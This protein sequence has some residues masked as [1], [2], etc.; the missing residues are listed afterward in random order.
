MTTCGP[1][2][3]TGVV[4]GRA[5]AVRR[6][7]SLDV[8]LPHP[9]TRSEGDG[10]VEP[11]LELAR[12]VVALELQEVVARRDLHDGGHVAPRP[13]RDDEHRD[14]HVED[15]ELLL[16]DAEPVVL[17]VGVPLHELE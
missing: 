13:D 2:A 12:R 15:A 4:T 11:L 7:R 10:A 6:L 5:R 3:R 9:A 17:D 16:L 1:A 8:D 14:L